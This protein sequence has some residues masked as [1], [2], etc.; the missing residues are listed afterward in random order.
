MRPILILSWASAPCAESASAA[1]AAKPRNIADIVVL[2]VSFPVIALLAAQSRAESI[3]PA[4]PCALW[5][6]AGAPANQHYT[7]VFRRAFA[8]K[9][10]IVGGGVGGLTTALML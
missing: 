2:L 10:I 4:L 5:R 7:R 3:F 8:M 1:T 6:V 9:A